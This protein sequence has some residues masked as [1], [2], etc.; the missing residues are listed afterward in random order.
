MKKIRSVKV[1]KLT[2]TSKGL[3]KGALL[4]ITKARLGGNNVSV[5]QGSPAT[6]SLASSS[7]QESSSEESE[8][9]SEEE[10]EMCRVLYQDVRDP[11]L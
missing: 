9:E 7:S 3:G 10:E 8:E 4:K 2:T 5:K 6:P 1:K 11:I